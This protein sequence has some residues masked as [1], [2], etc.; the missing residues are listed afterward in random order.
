MSAVRHC[1]FFRLNGD[2]TAQQ[3]E[4]LVEALRGM[5]AG[6]GLKD[7]VKALRVGEDLGIPHPSRPNACIASMVDFESQEGYEAYVKHPE[8]VKVIESFNKLIMEPGSR[9]ATQFNI[10]EVGQI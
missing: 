5:P 3:K 2:M 10:P 9:S 4:Q 7:I 6:E 1:V 8:H